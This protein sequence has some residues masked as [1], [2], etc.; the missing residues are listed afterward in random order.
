VPVHTGIRPAVPPVVVTGT[1]VTTAGVIAAAVGFSCE[2][3]V[4]QTVRRT[5]NPKP[6]LALKILFIQSPSTV[7]QSMVRSSYLTLQEKIAIKHRMP[8]VADNSMNY[9]GTRLLNQ[10]HTVQ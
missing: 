5:P 4:I 8:S 10:S 6:E 3:A 2:L 7:S 1:E 9:A